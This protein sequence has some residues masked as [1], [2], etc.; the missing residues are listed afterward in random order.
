MQE[1]QV[2]QSLNQVCR[3]LLPQIVINI[4]QV[5]AF[6]IVLEGYDGPQVAVE[7]LKYGNEC[8]YINDCFYRDKETASVNAMCMG[9]FFLGERERRKRGRWERGREK[10]FTTRHSLNLCWANNIFVAS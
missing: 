6:S 3:Q 5:H 1:K 8:R 2:E 4:L 9:D 7:S 10:I